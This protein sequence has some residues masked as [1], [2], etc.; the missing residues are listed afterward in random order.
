MTEPLAR[1]YSCESTQR[2]LS[3]EYQHDRVSMISKN[4]CILVLRTKVT[5][6]GK[7]TD[8]TKSG[9]LRMVIYWKWSFKYGDLLYVRYAYRSLSLCP[10]LV[11]SEPLQVG[12]PGDLLLDGLLRDL[13][14][15]LPQLVL[16][17]LLLQVTVLRLLLCILEQVTVCKLERERDRKY[18]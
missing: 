10:L 2:E 18:H 15:R 12:L 6:F 7:S 3:N 5:Q 1:G 17:H 11:I 14:V 8:R 9:H 13:P 4:L 16:Q